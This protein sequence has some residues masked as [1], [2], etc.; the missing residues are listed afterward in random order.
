MFVYTYLR[1]TDP[2]GYPKSRLPRDHVPG[3]EPFLCAE[4]PAH[5]MQMSTPWFTEA[6]AANRKDG[7]CHQHSLN[8]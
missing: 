5:S 1:R 4:V 7:R 8:S 3:C 6:L 2:V